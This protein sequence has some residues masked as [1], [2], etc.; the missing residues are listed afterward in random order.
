MKAWRRGLT[1]VECLVAIFII[2]FAILIM[3]A[4]FRSA[5]D[6]ARRANKVALATTIANKRMA[7]IVYDAQDPLQFAN[8]S[9]L[10]GSPFQDPQFGD[11]K[12]TTNSE[13]ETQYSPCSQA[14]LNYPAAQ[15][16]KLSSSLR[17]VRVQV[18]WSNNPRDVVTLINLVGAPPLNLTS[19]G[20]S[21]SIPDPINPAATQSLTVYGHD[22]GGGVIPDL[23]YEWTLAAET[24]NGELV[25]SR[26]GRSASL[27]NR[28]Y[29]QDLGY[30]TAPGSAEL[31]LRSHLATKSAASQTGVN[32]AP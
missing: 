15:Q 20:I 1:L 31:Q 4:L 24:G 12:V 8:W 2:T 28:I 17:K 27:T 21:E 29:D 9:A 22:A 23:F 26:D 18:S 11:F 10:D 14:E 32:F 25:V 16:R 7:Q 6:G 3:A 5:L 19:V 30:I 13:F